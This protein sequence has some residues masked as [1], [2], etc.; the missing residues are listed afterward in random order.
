MECKGCMAD[1]SNMHN[2]KE[3]TIKPDRDSRQW[4]EFEAV[5]K[6][7]NITTEDSSEFF[8]LLTKDVG[9]TIQGDFIGEARL[10]EKE[11]IPGALVTQDN[12]DKLGYRG[13]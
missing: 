4:L 5:C 3:I 7:C 6:H 10:L 13:L 2:L 9:V 8:I 12:K 1:L 11:V